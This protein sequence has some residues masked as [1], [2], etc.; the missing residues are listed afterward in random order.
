MDKSLRHEYGQRGVHL[1]E[2][3]SGGHLGDCGGEAHAAH[4][5]KDVKNFRDAAASRRAG[6]LEAANRLGA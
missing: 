3:I 2:F 4:L 6:G 1:G 5:K